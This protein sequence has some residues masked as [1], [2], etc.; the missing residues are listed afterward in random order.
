[1]SKKYIHNEII[2]GIRCHNYFNEKYHQIVN[3]LPEEA[4]SLDEYKI[5]NLNLY[6]FNNKLY[7]KINPEQYQIF[8][9]T[10]RNKYFQLRIPNGKKIYIK[11]DF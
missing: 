10:V 5:Y 3:T 6:Y 11:D 1:M 2:N 7:Y 9:P 4:I 8:K